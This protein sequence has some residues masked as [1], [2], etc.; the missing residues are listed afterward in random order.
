MRF[1]WRFAATLQMHRRVRA[2]F[3]CVS[4][5]AAAFR[6]CCERETHS[7]KRAAARSKSAF[8]A[9]PRRSIRKV[10]FRSAT[11]GLRSRRMTFATDQVIRRDMESGASES[12]TPSEHEIDKLFDTSENDK[13]FDAFMANASPLLVQFARDGGDTAAETAVSDWGEGETEGTNQCPDAGFDVPGG[14]VGA[15]RPPSPHVVPQPA[16]SKRSKTVPAQQQYTKLRYTPPCEGRRCGVW[17]GK[18][19]KGDKHEVY[20]AAF[21]DKQLR[22]CIDKPNKF[23]KLPPGNARKPAGS[24]GGAANGCLQA[25]ADRATPR[26]AGSSVR[27]APTVAHPQKEKHSLVRV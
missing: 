26:G 2:V 15:K 19:A 17:T 18:T 16:L 5:T 20:R 13:F 25:A 4:R 12:S 1:E 3:G 23:L 22:R 7:A 14:G 8:G 6:G 11:H 21:T 24:A 27:G 9:N 10:V